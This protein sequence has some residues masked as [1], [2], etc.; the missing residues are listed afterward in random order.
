[1]FANI[2]DEVVRQKRHEESESSALDSGA[3]SLHFIFPF[4]GI[5][6]TP[7]QLRH[8]YAGSDVSH[9]LISIVRVARKSSLEVK[10]VAA[11]YRELAKLPLPVIANLKDG[12]FPVVTSPRRPGFMQFLS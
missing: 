4:Y 9:D 10:T 2:R 6:S 5:S 8:S 11:Q 3:L 12:I 7:E 1:M